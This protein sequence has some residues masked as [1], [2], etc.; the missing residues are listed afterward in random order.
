MTN[1]TSL[2]IGGFGFNNQLFLTYR[3]ISALKNKT[4]IK[5]IKHTIKSG[6]NLAQNLKV[7]EDIINADRATKY[8]TDANNNRIAYNAFER[9]LYSGPSS[10]N[11]SQ[12]S[13]SIDN[14]VDMKIKRKV[15]GKDTTEKIRLIKS[16]NISSGYNMAAPKFNWSDFSTQATTDMFSNLLNINC[17]A[18]VSPYAIDNKGILQ[19]TWNHNGGGDWGRLTYAYTSATLRLASSKAK[20]KAVFIKIPTNINL[21]YILTYNKPGLTSTITQTVDISGSITLTPKWSFTYTTGY[22]IQSKELSITSFAINRDL[23][24]WNLSF[25]WVPF[26]ERKSWTFLLQPKANLLK[27]MKLQRENKWENQL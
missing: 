14:S 27:E 13:F 17:R 5:Y 4:R 26:G 10:T 8:Y 11:V 9:N 15:N 21:N 24:C 3:P 25:N 12:L 16:F 1:A 19:N 18:T 6:I 2:Q 22:D 20:T 23:H 7:V